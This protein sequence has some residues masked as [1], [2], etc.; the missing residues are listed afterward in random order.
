MDEMPYVDQ[1]GR[2]YKYGE[3]YPPELS[4]FAYNESSAQGHFPLDK[5]GAK[6]KGYR[7]REEDNQRNYQV[8]L[9]TTEIPADIDQVDDSILKEIIQCATPP[10]EKHLSNCVGAFRIIPAELKFYKKR[11]LPLPKYCPN[12]R[13]YQRLKY[14][15][16]LK[17]YRR[18]CMKEG[19]Q[20]EFETTFAPDRPEIIY[21]EQC[22]N[23]LVN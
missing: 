23:E 22:Y 20:N 3:F 11:G 10:E 13:R 17:L 2:I 9:K 15:N 4:L 5:E 8:T 7:W 21:C 1:R 14:R 6:E 18:K 12:C 16:P 19:C